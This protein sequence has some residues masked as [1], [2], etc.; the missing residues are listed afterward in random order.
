M[1]P[2]SASKR[3]YILVTLLV[4]LLM[5]VYAYYDATS[6]RQRIIKEKEKEILAIATLLDQQVPPQA[7]EMLLNENIRKLP[8]KERLALLNPI[9]Q[10]VL[11]AMGR[12]FPG[13]VMGYGVDE[14]R[15]ALYPPRPDLLEKPFAPD[16][17][18]ALKA[19]E[20]IFFNNSKNTVWG[21]PTVSVVLPNIVDG[22][23]VWFIWVNT[24]IDDV[25]FAYTEALTRSGLVFFLIW[26]GAML[27]LR[28]S[29]RRLEK[30]L[31]DLIAQIISR[32][33][34]INKL[35]EF[36]EMAPL[37]H[38]VTALR[39][40]LEEECGAKNQLNNEL[41]KINAQ[42]KWHSQLLD[43]AHDAIFVRDLS[44]KIIFWNN[45]AVVSYGWGREEVM[46]TVS[47]ETLKTVFPEPLDKIDS[48][49][50]TYGHWSG[51]LV[52][53]RKDGRQIIVISNWTLFKDEK[54]TPISI[55]E[56]NYDV[57][58][59]RLSEQ[60]FMKAFHSNP[61]MMGIAKIS[62]WTLL[63]VN[64]AYLDTMGMSR[65]DIIGRT[66]EEIGLWH[67]KEQ[68]GKLRRKIKTNN[69]TV[70][71]L[72][73]TIV[74][75]DNDVRSV[76]VSCENIFVGDEL[77]S[78][79]MFTDINDLR[80]YEEEIAHMERMNTIGEMAAGIG[81]E[82]RNPLTTVRGYLQ[83]FSRKQDYSNYYDQLTIMM[84]EL[85]RANDIISTFLSLAKNKTGEIKSGNFNDVIKEIHPLLEADALRRGHELWLKLGD[86]PETV[87]DKN[88]IRQLI[89]NLVRNGLEAMETSGSITISTFYNE[90]HA[91]IKVEDTGSG[92]PPEIMDKLG[93]PFFTTKASGT[94]LGLATCYRIANRHGA[95]IIIDSGETGTA[96]IIKFPEKPPETHDLIFVDELEEGNVRF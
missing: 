53:T 61:L 37:L 32:D 57:T 3:T 81:H 55:L 70:R 79:G 83:L 15:L 41:L 25:E 86:V 28:Y 10:P 52:H 84:E 75:K 76:L 49:L 7:E 21:K 11:E 67:D 44:N 95:K 16:G 63:D 92:I 48:T 89:L 94:G 91:F 40:G 19:K 6:I 23:V 77:C 73:M 12:R 22:E 69:G 65:E 36:P 39:K 64:Q 82:V 31:S 33:D 85:D 4:S 14:R 38:S 78:L 62:D 58:K 18:R 80:R 17:Q 35:S 51:E 50:M 68:L 45:G 2:K 26:V 60:R 5:I 46:N 71:N 74:A 96:F 29:F 87:F 20:L 1:I 90:G 56:I 13:H 42:L 54:G 88:E 72:E 34:D 24:K 66:P 47:H 9:L 43:M 8:H 93:T 59:Q 27:I 30:S